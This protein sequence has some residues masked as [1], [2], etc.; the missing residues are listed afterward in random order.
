MTL[1]YVADSKLVFPQVLDS[2]R[3]GW[4][5]EI[6]GVSWSHCGHRTVSARWACASPA[7]SRHPP[8]ILHRLVRAAPVDWVAVKVD[9]ANAFNTV[10]RQSI[11]AAVAALAPSLGQYAANA[12]GAHTTL[13]WG[14]VRLVSAAGVQQGDPLGPAFFSLALAMALRGTEAAP[15]TP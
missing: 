1:P 9:C 7:A 2:Q 12:Y 10:S 4:S 6:V 14:D 5:K 13:F 8:L 15:A 3:S 11:L